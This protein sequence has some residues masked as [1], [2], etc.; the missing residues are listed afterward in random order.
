MKNV[1]LGV[2][3]LAGPAAA[4]T[5]TP[6]SLSAK[7]KEA[8][9]EVEIEASERASVPNSTFSVVAYTK[10]RVLQIF[11]SKEDGYWL[12]AQGDTIT[13]VS[14]GGESGE[15]GVLFSG[16]PRIHVGNRYRAFLKRSLLDPGPSGT[17]FEVTGFERGLQPL[18]SLRAHSRNRTDGSNGEGNGAYLYWGVQYFP[19]PYFISSPSFKDLPEFV[20][21]IDASF[22]T[23]R[24]IEDIKVEFLAM[25][26]SAT[27][28]NE[29]DGVNNIIFIKQDWP[30]DPAAIAIT[31]NFYVAGTNDRSGL[32]LDTDILLNAVNHQ[33]TTTNENGKH[34]I[35]NIVT[36]EAG[37]FL[38]L[39]HEVSPA[40][41]EATMFA[42]ASTSELKKRSLYDSDLSGIREA[43]AG[44]GKKI[45]SPVSQCTPSSK[46]GC[47]AAHQPKDANQ[48]AI[49]TVIGFFL[50]LGF[51]LSAGR[52]INSSGSFS[53]RP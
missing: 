30:F 48:G 41:S 50:F 12:P 19:I 14:P 2:F 10:A 5:V 43:Y 38:G 44:V 6:E 20:S 4:L 37:H 26:C 35:Q 1:L 21:A 49:P 18:T 42:V 3:L 22:K 13:I 23:W 25:G 16:L 33:F 11:S 34:D 9:L 31:R 28:R 17:Y 32:I 46:S 24:D 40:D 36:H 51:T 47:A 7:L 39:G 29:N 52:R 8:V 45:G 53:S 27:T 15:V